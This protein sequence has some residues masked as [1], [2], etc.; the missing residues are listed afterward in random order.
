MT[1]RT[2]V[3]GLQGAAAVMAVALAVVGCGPAYEGP[4]P[5]AEVDPVLAAWEAAHDSAEL[6]QVQEV[7]TEDG[8]FFT[9]GDFQE[10]AE[11]PI[12]VADRLGVDGQEFIRRF[13]VHQGDDLSVADAMQVGARAIAFRWAWQ[14]F[15]AG[16]GT[17]SVRDGGI[18]ALV[19]TVAPTLT[20]PDEV[21]PVVEEFRRAAS[22]GDLDG[23]RG[24]FGDTVVFTTVAAGHA[25]YHDDGAGAAALVDGSQLDAWISDHEGEELGI[26]S[27]VQVGQGVA[28]AW[29]WSGGDAGTGV[30]SVEDGRIGAVALTNG[31]AAIPPADG[32][33]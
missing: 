1:C 28:F 3:R 17:M 27:P 26:R 30:M 16:T 2:R 8:V 21:D 31:T 22:A 12:L 11:R 15:A 14:D 10:L 9:L 13:R 32:A 24:L 19:L 6:D 20:M 4:A 5:A 25:A 33:S 23:L 29:G 18:A 7:F